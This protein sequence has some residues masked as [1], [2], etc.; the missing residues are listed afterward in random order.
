MLTPRPDI[1]AATTADITAN[2]DILIIYDGACPLCS[3]YVTLLRLRQHFVVE[4]LSARSD[5]QRVSY[6]QSRGYDLNQGIL[7]IMGDAVYAGADA[8]HVLAL[9]SRTDDVFNRLQYAIFSRKRLSRLLYPVLK[10]GRRLVLLL[11]GTPLIR[12]S[13]LP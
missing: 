5:D 7:L 12:H 10:A 3:A 11:R 8:M 1:A 4:L 13:P 9:C 2:S 6:F